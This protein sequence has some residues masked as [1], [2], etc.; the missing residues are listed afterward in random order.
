[1]K[2]QVRYKNA[3]NAIVIPDNYVR[4]VGTR[5]YVATWNGTS[6]QYEGPLRKSVA[7]ASGCSGWFCRTEKAIPGSGAMYSARKSDAIRMAARTYSWEVT[8]LYEVSDGVG[9]S[10]YWAETPWDALDQAAS[11]MLLSTSSRKTIFHELIVRN[12]KGQPSKTHAVHPRPPRCEDGAPHKWSTEHDLVGGIKENPGVWGGPNGG[13]TVVEG[14]LVCG[15]QKA[16]L[17]RMDT[18]FGDQ[19][20]GVEYKLGHYTE[21]LETLRTSRDEHSSTLDTVGG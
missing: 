12:A 9:T 13:V 5:W 7:K 14:C 15:C 20:E 4:K 17:T 10:L 3:M 11:H 1:M 6:A 18:G 21:K 8:R 16:T 19:A 2:P